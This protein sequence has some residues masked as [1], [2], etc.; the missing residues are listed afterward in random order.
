MHTVMTAPIASPR[1]QRGATAASQP[2]LLRRLSAALL[3]DM[4]AFAGG[5]ALAG[6]VTL[7]AGAGFMAA[8][9]APAPSPPQVAQLA[10]DEAIAA[11]PLSDALEKMASGS[12]LER[13]LVHVTPIATG[14]N[15]S[16]GFCREYELQRAGTQKVSGFACRRKDGRWS[17]AF[18]APSAAST[19]QASS[20]SNSTAEY[21]PA[22]GEGGGALDRFI[23][24]ASL[25][26]VLTGA[27]EAELISKGWPRD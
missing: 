12:A 19:D 14:P 25:G 5:L 26:D 16:G 10:D 11:G 21:E 1:C 7:I 20:S 27:D 13:G 24:A 2:S 8:R 3:P 18:H 9:M 6:C 4:P 22:S 17:I 15:T 23:A